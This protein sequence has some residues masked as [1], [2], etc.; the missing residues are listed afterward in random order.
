MAGRKVGEKVGRYGAG[1][2]KETAPGSGQW[3]YGVRINGRQVWR[4]SPRG[5]QL[6]AKQAERWKNEMYAQLVAEPP[7]QAVPV[8]ARTVGDLLNEWCDR[9][10]SARGVEWSR[11][12]KNDT[13]S[14][15]DHRIIP[16]LGD[17]RLADLTSV[18]IE[19]AYDQWSR[20]D[21]LTDS[22]VHRHAADVRSA[23]SFAARRGYEVGP[24]AGLAV[25]PP[26]PKSKAKPITIEQLPKLLDAAE[27]FGHD[28]LSA[29]C[30][31]ATTGARRGEIAALR[32]SDI[33]L[34][35]GT[36][37]VERQAVVVQGDV[38][39][40]DTKN[41]AQY[42]ARL[43]ARDVAVLNEVLDPG[44]PAHYVIG[45][46][47]KPINPN[48][49]TDGF[50]SVRGLAHVRGVTF[51]SLRHFWTTSMADAGVP[52]KD[53]ASGRWK[54]DRMPREVY[55]RHATLAGSDKMAEVELLPS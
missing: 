42:D 19:N 5:Q 37:R 49:I 39:I 9:G 52:M 36:I 21:G 10:R 40:E 32:W 8:P 2:L 3:D 43:S 22:S 4:R 20:E 14:R 13:R 29:I 23:L 15:L 6:T 44:E 50:T 53:I 25:A 35:R 1:S 33:D 18:D 38:F 12:Q 30:L 46:S 55:G 45:N 54:S 31:A 51:K 27:K 7:P 24:T 17:I 34:E 11:R 48:Q 47:A 41:D 16:T 28:M 26:Q